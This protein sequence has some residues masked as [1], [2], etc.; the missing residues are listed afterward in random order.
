MIP[1][2]RL[3][4]GRKILQCSPM[5]SLFTLHTRQELFSALVHKKVCTQMITFIYMYINVF[6]EQCLLTVNVLIVI[7]AIVKC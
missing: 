1:A 6:T 4:K 7:V 5:P 3:Y 2:R